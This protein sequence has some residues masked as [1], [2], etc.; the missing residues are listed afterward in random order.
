MLASPSLTSW[1]ALLISSLTS[2]WAHCSI[3]YPFFLSH[4]Q[5]LPLHWLLPGSL[6][7]CLSLIYSRKPKKK[8]ILF[9]ILPTSEVISL[10]LTFPRQPGFLIEFTP[11]LSSLYHHL[12]TP[13]TRADCLVASSICWCSCSTDHQYPSKTLLHSLFC[14][15]CLW[16]IISSYGQ[17]LTFSSQW[18][19]S[20]ALGLPSRFFP[21]IGN[22][23]IG[24]S[25]E[26]YE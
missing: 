8:K 15:S 20:H 12:Y 26:C 21:T 23:N 19:S 14:L 13:W 6:Q 22:K 24:E 2:P 9:S 7:T 10:S 4:L 17:S 18:V 5:S 3:N 11:H 25:G 1:P 16:P